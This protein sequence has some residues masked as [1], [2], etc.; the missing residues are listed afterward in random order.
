MDAAKQFLEEVKMEEN[1]ELMVDAGNE[2]DNVEKTRKQPTPVS[3]QCDLIEGSVTCNKVVE[4]EQNDPS[5]GSVTCNEVKQS[6][7]NEGSLTCNVVVEHKQSEPSEGS[8]TCN[9]AEEAQ[10]N[11]NKGTATYNG[12]Y[13]DPAG[14]GTT[15]ESFNGETLKEQVNGRCDERREPSANFLSGTMK[16]SS[17]NK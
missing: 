5:E 6:D 1:G 17:S 11:Q 13:N 14:D 15:A 3:G 16:C 9:K 8:V 7:L 10:N 2:G 4:H 12:E